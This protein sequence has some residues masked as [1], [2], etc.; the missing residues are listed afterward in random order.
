MSNDRLIRHDPCPDCGS[1]DN[2]AIYDDHEHCFTEGCGRHVFYN[3]DN[4]KSQRSQADKR[5]K[6]LKKNEAP[7]SPLSQAAKESVPKSLIPVMAGPAVA[8]KSRGLNAETVA[9]YQ[10]SISQN[11]DNEIEAVFPRF[12]DEGQHVGNQIRL[13]GKKFKCQGEINQAGL[14]GQSLFPAGGRSITVTEGYYDAM[15]AYQLTKSRYPNVG[16]MSASTAKK[17]FVNSFEYLNSFDKIV[18]NFDSDDPGQKAARECANLFSPGKCAILKLQRGKDANEYLT[19]GLL[20]EYIDEWFRAPPYM[21]DGLQLGS[22]PKLLEEILSYKE[23]RSIPYPWDGLNYKTYGIRT[24]ELVL[25][26]AD[27][28]DGKTTVMKEIEYAL[29]THPELIAEEKGVGFL[30]FEEPKRDLTMGLM[31][32]HN[33]KPYHFPDV[34]RTEDELTKAYNDVLNNDRVVIWDH[35]G[36][37]DIDVVLAKIRHMA[38]LGCC[39]IMV[40]HLS[41]I[42]SDQSGDERKQLDEISTKIKTLTMNLDIA[43]FC[44]IHINRN[45]QVRGSAGPEQVANIVLRLERDKKDPDD[46][47]RNITRISVEKN[48]KYG[49]TGPACYLFYN[50]IT[51]R[52]QQLSTELAQVYESGG[53]LAGHEFAAYDERV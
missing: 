48:R 18:I 14:F 36:S 15:S 7:D 53:N 20:N 2:L 30:H 45:G 9:R 38:A 42:V 3:N 11:P 23:P 19:G 25:L 21:P 6:K 16:V 51:G 35:F 12:N 10:V 46:W 4:P 34:E 5:E 50:E 8:L 17:E 24:S 37:N 31:S 26:T 33:S 29:L 52:L 22:D 49:R 28:G 40:D 47:R 39:Y 41:I 27:T 44:V 43:V 1:T 13:E 32:V